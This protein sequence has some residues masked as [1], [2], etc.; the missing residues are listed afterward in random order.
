MTSS[1]RNRRKVGSRAGRSHAPEHRSAH[2]HDE[3]V[4]HAFGV[5]DGH[6]VAVAR[7]CER[8]DGPV[9]RGN[10]LGLREGE[11]W[12]RQMDKAKEDVS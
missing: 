8:G 4:E 11:R 5:V 3:H 2:D 1:H 7:G 10:V 6:D 9:Q 12:E